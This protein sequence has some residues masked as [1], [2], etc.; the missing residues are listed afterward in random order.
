MRRRRCSQH[1]LLQ[2][3]PWSN[4]KQARVSL[5][6]RRVRLS[7][8][9]HVR[10][11][12]GQTSSTRN[13]QQ[14]AG[15]RVAASSGALAGNGRHDRA[16]GTG[17]GT[18]RVQVGSLLSGNCARGTRGTGRARGRTRRAA[19]GRQTGDW[20]GIRSAGASMH[21]RCRRVPI[22]RSGLWAESYAQLAAA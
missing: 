19:G 18:R 16:P 10:V 13:V 8:H 3:Q 9:R 17:L 15:R 6:C 14:L 7:T 2:G 20:H 4:R 11:G 5:A 12:R 22:R 21:R 1:L